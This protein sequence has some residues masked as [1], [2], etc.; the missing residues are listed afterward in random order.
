[1]SKTPYV[2]LTTDKI[3]DKR[4]LQNDIWYKKLKRQYKRHTYNRKISSS[5]K[6]QRSSNK[7]NNHISGNHSLVKLL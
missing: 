1:M 4:T 2:C 7:E 5:K 3:Q 6:Q